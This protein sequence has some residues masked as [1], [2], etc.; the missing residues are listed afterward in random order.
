MSI[1]TLTE[2]ILQKMPQTGKVQ[3]RFF[4]RLLT[5][6][7]ALRG[8]YC[9]ANLVRQGF[10]NPMS[11]RLNFGK[12]FDFATFN[13]LL[14]QAHAGSERILA[15]DPCFL[16]KAGKHTPGIGYFWSGCAQALKRGLEISCLAVVD[17]A[18]TTAFHYQASQT[19]LDKGQTLLD[20]YTRLLVGQADSLAAL[21]KY[22]AVD[23]FFAKH[24]FVSA[25]Q[26]SG[27]QVITRLR[28]DAA[29]WYPYQGF[30]SAKAGRPRKYVGKVNLRQPDPAYFTC[31]E[32]TAEQVAYQA[33]LY[34]KSLK[35]ALK[36]V[37]VHRLGSQMS[38]KGVQV[39]VCTDTELS[40]DKLWHYYR[41]R[42][43]QEFLFRD[44]KQHLGLAH[45]QSRHPK[46]IAFQV[47][48]AL[49]VLSVAKVV[50]WLSVPLGQ[51]KAFSI[52]DIKTRYANQDLLDR[53]I[54]G[55]G[56]CSKT[57]QNSLLYRQLINY[58]TIYP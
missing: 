21:S 33:V 11:Y 3:T 41:L 36:V 19:R 30:R 27:L 5:Q 29:L 52:Q 17:V 49:S 12:P 44:G 55:L 35:T 1:E 53:L 28:S 22:L 14:I 50:H 45:C 15:F 48:F 38:I 8:R 25:L 51:R 40:G 24:G 37:L 42:F 47:N 4:I 9:F 7:L 10:L 16:A 26:Q 20:F 13:R 6:W 31:L 2:Q 54:N 23:A 18:N 39:L 46:R 57:L 34:S 56:L 58:A 43:Q 32:A